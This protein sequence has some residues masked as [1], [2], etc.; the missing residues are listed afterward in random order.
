[1]TDTGI[2][3]TPLTGLFLTAVLRTRLYSFFDPAPFSACFLKYSSRDKNT[4]S[5]LLDCSKA[6]FRNGGKS[7]AEQRV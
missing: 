1:M 4:F 2:D 3:C 6:V 5:E 7:V